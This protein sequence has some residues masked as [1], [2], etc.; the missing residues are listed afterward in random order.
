MI[1]AD[2]VAKRVFNAL[3]VSIFFMGG[4]FGIFFSLFV[5]LF[6]C[7]NIFKEIGFLAIVPCLGALLGLVGSVFFAIIAAAIIWNA[8]KGQSPFK[9]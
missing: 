3:F 2:E 6:V 9:G 8:L 1:D 7:P 4:L 5:L